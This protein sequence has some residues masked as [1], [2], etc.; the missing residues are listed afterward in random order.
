M[1]PLLWSLCVVQFG[2][3]SVLATKFFGSSDSSPSKKE[4]TP[5][6]SGSVVA[7]EGG[8]VRR[9]TMFKVPDPENQKKFVDAYERLR[10]EQ[11]KV[12][13]VSSYTRTKLIV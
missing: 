1:H 3:L 8:K 13:S 6:M 10:E 5:K 9:I 2:L 4:A 12:F 7:T 11:Q